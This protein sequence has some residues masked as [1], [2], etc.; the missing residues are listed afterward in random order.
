MIYSNSPNTLQLGYVQS[1]W[2]NIKNDL[3]LLKHTFRCLY[4]WQMDRDII[5][6]FHGNQ[7]TLT[8]DVY[9][10]TEQNSVTVNQTLIQEALSDGQP[11]LYGVKSSYLGRDFRSTPAGTNV[12]NDKP[13]WLCILFSRVQ[14]FSFMNWS[15]PD[16]VGGDL[17][18]SI[19]HLYQ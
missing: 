13:R 18:P 3:N 10:E 4:H 17:F 16:D 2:I 14:F 8:Y 19:G 9:T 6:T 7:L 11:H 15:F 12:T 5:L 1:I